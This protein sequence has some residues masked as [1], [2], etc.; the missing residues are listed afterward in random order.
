MATATRAKF[1]RWIGHD[2]VITQAAS[3]RGTFTP[4]FCH[5]ILDSVG[6]SGDGDTDPECASERADFVKGYSHDLPSQSKAYVARL[7][8]FT[9]WILNYNLTWLTGDLIAG[10]T[11]GLV[12]VPQSMVRSSFSRRNRPPS[13]LTLY[14]RIRLY[15]SQSYAKIATL[16]AQ[17]GLYSS[18]VGVLIYVSLSLSKFGLPRLFSRRIADSRAL[19]RRCGRLP[20]MSLSVQLRSCR[21]KSVRSS[22]TSRRNPVATSTRV[23][24]SPPRSPSSAVVRSSVWACCV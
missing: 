7:F 4:Y 14:A 2:P 10:F 6:G 23:T 9:K 20:R 24:S 16:P 13:L 21:S 11:V 18:F 8:P 19:A 3:A 5:S 1:L 22:R 15:F 17:Y 12:V